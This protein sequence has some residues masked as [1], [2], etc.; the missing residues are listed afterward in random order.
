[1]ETKLQVTDQPSRGSCTGERHRQADSS[2]DAMIMDDESQKLL[3]S[4]LII[5]LTFQVELLVLVSA[6][7]GKEG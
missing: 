6:R 3:D 2:A 5:V 1:M 7:A 4:Q